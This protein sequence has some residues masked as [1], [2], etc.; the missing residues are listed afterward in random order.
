MPLWVPSL[1]RG[2]GSGCARRPRLTSDGDQLLMHIAGIRLLA[3]FELW[4][5]HR[6]ME[7]GW[8]EDSADAERGQNG[9]DFAQQ[10]RSVSVSRQR[11]A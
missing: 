4:G 3:V 9:V 10:R 11:A 7:H 2:F 6:Q 1:A 5:F 8:V